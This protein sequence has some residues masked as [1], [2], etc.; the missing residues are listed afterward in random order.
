MSFWI[1]VVKI[2]KPLSKLDL[3]TL[4][5]GS[6]EE[7][8]QQNKWKIWHSL[9]L[10]PRSPAFLVLWVPVAEPEFAYA[11]IVVKI[12]NIAYFNNNV[13]SKRHIIIRTAILYIYIIVGVEGQLT[14][15]WPL[16]CVNYHLS[17]CV[18]IPCLIHLGWPNL[19]IFFWRFCV[20]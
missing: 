19:V 17:Y 11:I 10:E 9:G 13:D 20:N 18:H 3:P 16:L 15:V 8:T 1:N 2:C 4:R 12:C 7:R 6:I 14:Y 5:K